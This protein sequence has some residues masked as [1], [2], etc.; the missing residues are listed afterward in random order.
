MYGAKYCGGGGESRLDLTTSATTTTGVSSSLLSQDLLLSWGVDGR[1]VLWDSFSQGQVRAPLAILKSYNDGGDE[2]DHHGDSTTST[3]TTNTKNPYPIYTVDVSDTSV[4]VGGGGN[5]GGFLGIPVHLYDL[6]RASA[7]TVSS[8][9]SAKK[10]DHDKA[11][12]DD[13][14]GDDKA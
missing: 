10:N 4:A 3:T 12:Q 8:I 13:D 1:L 11:K 5:D 2:N 9:T 14:N 6:W 7:A